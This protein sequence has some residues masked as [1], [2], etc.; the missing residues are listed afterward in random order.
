VLASFVIT[1]R[2]EQDLTLP[3]LGGE[4]LHGLFFEALRTHDAAFAEHLHNLE[5]DTPL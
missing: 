3:G 5:G 4:A 2:G 1:L